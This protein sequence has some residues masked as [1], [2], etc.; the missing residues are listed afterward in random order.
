[1]YLQHPHCPYDAGRGCESVG[2]D[3]GEGR[4]VGRRHQG[5]LHGGGLDGAAGAP[6]EG[7]QRGLQEVQGECAL[8][9]K[10]GNARGTLY[11]KSAITTHK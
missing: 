4:S 7:D 9:E 5:H 6:N 1:T 10:G 11:V 2:V 8:P 3:H